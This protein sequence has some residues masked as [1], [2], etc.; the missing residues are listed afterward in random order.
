MSDLPFDSETLS[1]SVRQ[2]LGQLRA[3][4]EGASPCHD[5]LLTSVSPF[6]LL[7]RYPQRLSKPNAI[8]TLPTAQRLQSIERAWLDA[9][10]NRDAAAF[11]KFAADDW[12]A[13]T[14]D[15]LFRGS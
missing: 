14:P 5:F 8:P 9:E 15:R 13:I 11:E 3:V 1:P 7:P 6:S 2:E 10:K 12:M 4:C